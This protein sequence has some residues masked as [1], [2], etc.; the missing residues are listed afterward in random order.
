MQALTGQ[1]LIAGP[2]LWDPN[3]R[4]AVVLVGH[5]DEE[6]AL[7]VVLNRSFDVPVREVVPAV[8]G[9]VG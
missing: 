4:R 3:F 6:G 2:S 7:G 5:H 9:L 1:L 8:G